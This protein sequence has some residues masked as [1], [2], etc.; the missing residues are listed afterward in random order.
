MS[1]EEKQLIE[2]AGE[3]LMFCYNLRYRNDFFYKDS[4]NS[5]EI[6]GYCVR[7]SYENLSI[8]SPN[9]DVI[10][11][12]DWMV[13]VH[14]TYQA[15]NC[16]RMVVD[17]NHHIAHINLAAEGS[18]N[19]NMVLYEVFQKSPKVFYLILRMK[20]LILLS[21]NNDSLIEKR[22]KYAQDEIDKLN[23]WKNFINNS[24]KDTTNG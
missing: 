7:M 19:I 15:I 12:I 22:I 18:L 4:G 2:E 8:R 24:L 23:S 3:S 17:S 14:G 5:W 10:I 9:F 20:Q 6:D 21:L 13:K 1:K 11:R 16:A